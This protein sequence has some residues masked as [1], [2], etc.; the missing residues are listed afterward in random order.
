M[1]IFYQKRFFGKKNIEKIDSESNGIAD[2]N[3]PSTEN[4]NA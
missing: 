1:I 3:T 4:V 2:S